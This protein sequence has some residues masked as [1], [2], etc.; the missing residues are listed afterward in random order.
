MSQLNRLALVAACALAAGP[1][2]AAGIDYP[3][4][5][6]SAMGTSHANAAEAADASAV[7]FNPAGITRFKTPVKS[8]SVQALSIRGRFTDEGT[9]RANGEAAG[10]GPAGSYHPQVIGGAQSYFVRP[11]DGDLT[12]GFGLFVPYG[13]NVN[14][15]SDFPGRYFGDRAAIETL[16]LNPVLAL[17]FDDQHAVAFGVSGQLSHAKVKLG[18]DLEEAVRAIGLDTVQNFVPGVTPPLCQLGSLLP[19]DLCATVADTLVNSNGGYEAGFPFFD[20][21]GYGFGLGYNLGYQFSPS[22]TTRFSLAYRSQIRQTLRGEVDWN[23]DG[24]TGTLPNPDDPLGPRVDAKTFA[25]TQVR[26]D[27]KAKLRIT[28][29]DSLIAGVFHQFNARLALMASVQ[30]QRYSVIREMRVQLNDPNQGDATVRTHFRDTVRLGLGAN[31][32][33]SEK[34]L[35]RGGLGY[36]MTPVPNAESRHATVPDA[37]RYNLSLGMNYQLNDRFSLD[38]AYAFILLA[39]ARSNYTDLCHPAGYST[40][41]GRADDNR[42]DK[43]FSQ[44]TGNGGTFRGRFTDTTIHSVGAQLNHRF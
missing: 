22:E 18:A 2:R 23:F 29:P 34:V 14:Y 43:D 35:L 4:M 38:F 5:S 1:V 40:T 36:D 6:T 32:R 30:F 7:Y 25:E 17:R 21:E 28:T 41:D 13:A 42:P 26:P 31:Y 27:S 39:D 24:V 12:F 9:T 33:W 19:L 37:D 44:C 10:G 15:K 11:I 20:F 16:N 3:W 8:D